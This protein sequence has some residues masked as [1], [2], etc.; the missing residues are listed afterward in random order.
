M[1][2][3]TRILLVLFFALPVAFSSC[4]KNDPE[5]E[6]EISSADE[7]HARMKKQLAE[8][9][10]EAE[11]FREVIANSMN[12]QAIDQLSPEEL[13]QLRESGIKLPDSVEL[14]PEE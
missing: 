2:L 8:L 4:E 12:R 10:N 14:P 6:P 11:E 7:A 1:S 9:E 5:P 13:E 3:D